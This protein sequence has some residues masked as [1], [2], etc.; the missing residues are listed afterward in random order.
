MN[1]VV[2]S[3]EEAVSDIFDGA[4]TCPAFRANVLNYCGTDTPKHDLFLA[5]HDRPR[6]K[7]YAEH[8]VACHRREAS[9][10]RGRRLKV[11]CPFLGVK[12]CS[13]SVRV[14]RME[15]A[16]AFANVGGVESA[17]ANEK[18]LPCRGSIPGGISHILF[19]LVWVT[20]SAQYAL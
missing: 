7:R 16:S 10:C 1:K 15:A 13:S 6:V 3:T 2:A 9:G 17:W 20:A 5:K 18:T 14:Q 8:G 19:M 12:T 4:T 11:S